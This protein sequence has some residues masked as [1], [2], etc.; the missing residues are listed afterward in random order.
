MIAEPEC[1]WPISF[2]LSLKNEVAY[3]FRY[4]VYLLAIALVVTYFAFDWH[5]TPRVDGYTDEGGMY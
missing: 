5:F 4:L 1:Y 3:Q 2:E